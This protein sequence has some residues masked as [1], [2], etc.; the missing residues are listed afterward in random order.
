[1]DEKKYKKI[2]EEIIEGKPKIFKTELDKSIEKIKSYPKGFEFTIKYSSLPSKEKENGMRW[3]LESAR[4]LGLIE[5]IAI[6][7][8]LRDIRGE[9]GRI[10]NEEKFRK[11]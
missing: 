7:L 4:K 9:S 3:I 5:S 8:S 6:G 11:I 1:M 2:Y 10:N